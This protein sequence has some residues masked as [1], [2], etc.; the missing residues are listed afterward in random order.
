MIITMDRKSKIKLKI[1]P[2]IK[3]I[4]KENIL[5]GH[6]II[7]KETNLSNPII[8]KSLAREKVDFNIWDNLTLMKILR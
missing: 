2:K 8:N 5:W 7:N 1:K 6:Q 4:D 3:I